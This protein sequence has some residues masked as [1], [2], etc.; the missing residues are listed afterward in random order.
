MPSKLPYLENLP[1]VSQK[2]T[3]W[4]SEGS[5]QDTYKI[6]YWVLSLRTGRYLLSKFHL[7]DRNASTQFAKKNGTE[8]A[9]IFDAKLIEIGI[10][11]AFRL[12]R[13]LMS[14]FMTVSDNTNVNLK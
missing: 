1:Q 7:C 14:L 3:K 5:S 4:Y 8:K 12:S 10:F 13:K 2:I 6:F 11:G 9:Y